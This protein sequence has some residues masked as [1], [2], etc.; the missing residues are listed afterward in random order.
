LWDEAY[1]FTGDVVFN[2]GLEAPKLKKAPFE[3]Q[4]ISNDTL[5]VFKNY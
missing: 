5:K 4:E 2:E 1:V 3:I